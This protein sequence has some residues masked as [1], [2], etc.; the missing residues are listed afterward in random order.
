M[1]NFYDKYKLHFDEMVMMSAL[2]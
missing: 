1:S 2:Y